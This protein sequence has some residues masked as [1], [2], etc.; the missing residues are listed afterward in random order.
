MAHMGT[1][2]DWFVWPFDEFTASCSQVLYYVV[3]L[4]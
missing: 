1:A 2:F 3:F 4:S